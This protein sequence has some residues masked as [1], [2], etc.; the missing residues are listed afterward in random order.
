[1]AIKN[2]K[3]GVSVSA[4]WNGEDFFPGLVKQVTSK[5][6][7]IIWADGD[8]PSLV[9]LDQVNELTSVDGVS[10]DRIE[11][12]RF[13]KLQ[14][15]TRS[16]RRF[17]DA[18]VIV[19]EIKVDLDAETKEPLL[20]LHTSTIKQ[21]A[22][23]PDNKGEKMTMHFVVETRHLGP[24]N[25]KPKADPKPT[26]TKAKAKKAP[27]K[28]IGTARTATK[29]ATGKR[30]TGVVA[31]AV[32]IDLKKATPD[33]IATCFKWAGLD[34]KPIARQRDLTTKEQLTMLSREGF[35]F[36]ID[37]KGFTYAA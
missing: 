28:A 13:Y 24:T 12:G 30:T 20:R 4:L 11:V 21:F 1:M 26:N 17:N 18:V 15:M 5:N 9:P 16:S 6:A 34:E 35:K 29:K 8:E 7:K 2:L 31:K 33:Q 14:K 37:N 3:A 23:S 10:V 19:T 22:N 32:Q 36:C 25:Y 27:A